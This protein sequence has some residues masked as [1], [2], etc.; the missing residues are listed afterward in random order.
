MEGG[1]GGERW[2]GRRENFTTARWGW[3]YSGRREGGGEMEGA[4]REFHDS[5][6]G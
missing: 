4:E 5:T 3:G 2:R 1:K 6:V